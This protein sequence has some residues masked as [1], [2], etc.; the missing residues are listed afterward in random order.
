MKGN[1]VFNQV[2]ETGDHGPFNRC[3]SSSI[4]SS[5]DRRPRPIQ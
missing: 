1:L 5:I 2:R 4:S 3:G